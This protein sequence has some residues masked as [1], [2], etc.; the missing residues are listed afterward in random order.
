[1]LRNS[2]CSLTEFNQ[3]LKGEADFQKPSPLFTQGIESCLSFLSLCLHTLGPAQQVLLTLFQVLHQWVQ[4]FVLLFKTG[5]LIDKVI[6][7]PG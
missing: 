1:M 5:Y 3:R 7:L 6:P 4:E 2:L